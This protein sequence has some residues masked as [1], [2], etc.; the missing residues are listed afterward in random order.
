[1]LSDAVAT[2]MGDND[3]NVR[4]L[5]PFCRFYNL[6]AATVFKYGLK[7]LATVDPEDFVEAIHHSMK[8]E[9][10]S[11]LKTPIRAFYELC[12]EEV[13]KEESLAL[14]NVRYKMRQAWETQII[15]RSDK[16]KKARIEQS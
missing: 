2:E 14:E 9:W 5:K 3:L 13:D 16:F 6:M 11:D 15:K 7:N 8:K 10:R 4:V 1:M 12:K